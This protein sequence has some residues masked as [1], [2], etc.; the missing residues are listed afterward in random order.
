MRPSMWRRT[1]NNR[2]YF[3]RSRAVLAGVATWAAS[4]SYRHQTRAR[5][6]GCED[7][8]ISCQRPALCEYPSLME[9]ICEYLPR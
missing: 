6:I 4:A 9:S 7:N 3:G 1:N 8:T 5:A 2:D